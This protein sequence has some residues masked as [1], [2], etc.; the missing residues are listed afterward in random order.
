M[1]IHNKNHSEIYEVK[2]IA[3]KKQIRYTY[4]NKQGEVRKDVNRYGEQ[5]R[6]WNTGFFKTKRAE[7]FLY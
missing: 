3:L 6:N 2:S 1:K 5:C 7:S 4:Y